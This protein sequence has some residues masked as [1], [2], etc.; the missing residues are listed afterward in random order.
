MSVLCTHPSHAPIVPCVPPNSK[1]IANG[2]KHGCLQVT[3]GATGTQPGQVGMGTNQGTGQLSSQGFPGQ[4]S[5]MGGAVGTNT[6]MGG[7][8]GQG[9]VTEQGTQGQH[10]GGGSMMDALDDW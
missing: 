5:N 1:Y 6:N 4:S 3:S 8:S 9:H 10:R 2:H 7:M